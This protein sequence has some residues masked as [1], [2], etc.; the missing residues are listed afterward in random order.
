M[1]AIQ[2][3]LDQD[4]ARLR[5]GKEGIYNPTFP[6]GLAGRQRH[7]RETLPITVVGVN[8]N[9]GLGRMR[10]ELGRVAFSA[11]N[12]SMGRRRRTSLS[13]NT[14]A[15]YSS[16]ISFEEDDAV[17]TERVNEENSESGSTGCTSER[18]EREDGGDAEGEEDLTG[19][20]ICWDLEEV[21]GLELH[22]TPEIPFE[23][24]DDFLG[25]K[26]VLIS[27]PTITSVDQDNSS[28]SFEP[29]SLEQDHLLAV[30]RP[31]T[32][33]KTSSRKKSLLS[34]DSPKV[35]LCDLD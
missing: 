4:E 27:P 3:K 25:E 16:S 35:P 30:G 19:D 11:T 14:N 26:Q 9:E 34:S 20:D 1:C 12:M 5:G 2:S 13:T 28:S 6:N 29:S 15:N 23:D 17:W 8:V 10:R 24:D 21:N 22:A 31:K 18:D 33:K 7:W 32:R